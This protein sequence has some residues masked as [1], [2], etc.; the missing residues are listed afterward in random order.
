MSGVECERCG[1]PGATY[2]LVTPATHWSPAEYE[3]VCETCDE[4]ATQERD[5]DRAA[6]E[7][8][9]DERRDERRNWFVGGLR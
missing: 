8:R 4:A 1:G 2:G 7:D 5:W 6:E 9:D 3:A